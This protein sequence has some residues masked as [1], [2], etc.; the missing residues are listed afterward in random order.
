MRS[1]ALV[2][3]L[4]RYYPQMPVF[5]RAP[6]GWTVEIAINASP[7]GM[8][9]NDPLPYPVEELGDAL[10]VA[11]AVTAPPVTPWLTEAEKRGLAVQTGEEMAFAQV[12]IQL[13][14][15]RLQ[16]ARRESQDRRRGEPTDAVERGA[17]G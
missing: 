15:L 9:P 12:P 5:D 2:G 10:I 17:L 4:G 14:Y 7:A 13:Q 1:R 11:D 3:E 16:P 6:P 8:S